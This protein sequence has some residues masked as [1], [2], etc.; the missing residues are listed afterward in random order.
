MMFFNGKE[1]FVKQQLTDVQQCISEPFL[2][3]IDDSTENG[4][5]FLSA[6]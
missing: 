5:T 3:V 2:M 6:K 1:N 4:H